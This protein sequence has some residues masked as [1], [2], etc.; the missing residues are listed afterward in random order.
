MCNDD[1]ISDFTYLFFMTVSSCLLSPSHYLCLQISGDSTVPMINQLLGKTFPE[2]KSS[3]FNSHRKATITADAGGRLSAEI[4]YN[5][6][7]SSKHIT[8]LL[9][10]FLAKTVSRI[11]DVY[12]PNVNLSFA[13]QPDCNSS[14]PRAIR[15]GDM[16]ADNYFI[17]CHDENVSNS[18]FEIS[19][20]WAICSYMASHYAYAILWGASS[21]ISK[22]DNFLCPL[23]VFLGCLIA[24]IDLKKVSTMDASDCLVATYARKLQGLRAPEKASLQV[25]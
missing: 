6:E 1:I 22:N 13:M 24:G 3:A 2:V 19:L 11:T 16:K 18:I 23:L 9:G 25:K 5:D 21:H 7:T 14:V 20:L 12:G 10:M 4:S 15:E 8:S 17:A